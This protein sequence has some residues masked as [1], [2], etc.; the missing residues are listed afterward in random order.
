MSVPREPMQLEDSP[1]EPRLMTINSRQDR[2]AQLNSWS[3]QQ[4]SSLEAKSL[5]GFI[6]KNRSPSCGLSKVP[7]TISNSNAAKNRVVDG[8]GLFAMEIKKHFPQ[9]PMVEED[10]L[11]SSSAIDNFLER[12]KLFREQVA[13][14]SRVDHG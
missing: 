1:K 13:A 7:V 11:S 9:M 3:K 10:D 4:I 8:V 14:I 6:F 2:T 12:V 5:S